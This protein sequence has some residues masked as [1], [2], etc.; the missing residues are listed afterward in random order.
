MAMEEEVYLQMC[1]R[2]RSLPKPLVAAAQET[3][4]GA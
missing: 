1:L 2:W 4:A 3:I